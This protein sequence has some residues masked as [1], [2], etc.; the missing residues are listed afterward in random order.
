M[1]QSMLVN[2]VESLHIHELKGRMK[3]MNTGAEDLH[4]NTKFQILH[5]NSQILVQSISV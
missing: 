2:F 3:S 1:I 5:N 4:L